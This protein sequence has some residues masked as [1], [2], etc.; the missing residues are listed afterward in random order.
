[1]EKTQKQLSLIL[2]KDCKMITRSREAT[3]EEL[4]LIESWVKFQKQISCFKEGGEK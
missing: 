2:A 3:Y 1:M 4:E